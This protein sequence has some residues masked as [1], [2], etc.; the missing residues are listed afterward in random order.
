[1]YKLR[2]VSPESS[3]GE[4]QESCDVINA[5]NEYGQSDDDDFSLLSVATIYDENGLETKKL[6]NIGLGWETIINM[7]IP[8]PVS[9]LKQNVLHK[10]KLR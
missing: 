1:M 9:F 6:P 4:I 10:L 3:W 7:N 5:W 2:I 8:S